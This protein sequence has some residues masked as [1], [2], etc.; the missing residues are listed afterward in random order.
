MPAPLFSFLRSTAFVTRSAGI[1][2]H[3][4][5]LH[6]RIPCGHS[7]SWTSTTGLIGKLS[8]RSVSYRRY[9]LFDVLPDEFIYDPFRSKSLTATA[10]KLEGL[11]RPMGNLQHVHRHPGSLAD[12]RGHFPQCEQIRYGRLRCGGHSGFLPSRP[13]NFFSFVTAEHHIMQG[14]FQ[15]FMARFHR[16][17]P[18][19]A[20]KKDVPVFS[21]HILPDGPRHKAGG[22]PRC[23]PPRG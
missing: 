17:A 12:I 8:V 19:S 2:A 4:P 6:Q 16:S 1:T 18:L 14:R 21:F 7:R 15:L 13:G 11:N 22:S 3:R 10:R 23:K 20:R 9:A 5:P